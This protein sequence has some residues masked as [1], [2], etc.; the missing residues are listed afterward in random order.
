MNYIYHQL[1]SNPLVI[2]LLFCLTLFSIPLFAS[3]PTGK[4]QITGIVADA[5]S[6]KTIPY[7]TVTLQ[8]SKGIIKRLAS[9]TNG[10][11]EFTLDSI[12][13]YTVLVQSIGFQTLKNEVN[14]DEKSTKIELGILKLTPGTEKIDEV[15]VVAQKP[16]VRT[17]VD[18]IIYSIEADPESKTSNALDMLR[19]IP[20]V[21]VDGEDNIQVK[22]SSNFK[23]LLNGKS[24]SMLT[25]N[26][27]DVLRS[28]PASTIKDIEVIT[29]P[30]SKYEAEGTG[31][32][33]NIITAKKQLE[34]FLGRINAGIDTRGG[35]TGGIYAS[36]KIKKF[37]FSIDYSYGDWRNPKSEN[38]SSLEN[39][40]STTNRFT[41]SEGYNKYKGSYN[42]ATGEASYEIDSLNLISLSFWGYSGD[43]SAT[44]EQLT[45][46]F[47]SNYTLSRKFTNL[48]N[49]S[50]GYGYISGN[51]D[52]QR[53]YKKPDKTFT[54]SYKLETMPRQSDN[55]SN[56][57]GQLNYN[58]YRQRSTNDASVAEHTFQLD[59]YDPLTKKHQIE[60]GVKYIFRHNISNSEISRY[61]YNQNDWI[62]D[63]SRNNDLNYDQHV[64]GLYAGYVLKL[65]KISIKS[66]LRQEGT[67]NDGYFHSVKDTTFTNRM[68]NLIP[69]LT[70]SKELDK[71][72]N[73][74]LSY[75]QRLA[76]PGIWYLNPYINDTDPLN[77][78]YGNPD[79]DA[80]VSHTFNLSYGKFSDKYN[81][82]LSTNGAFANNSIQSI[83]TI[84]ST[85]VKR[86]TY[87]NIGK[88]QRYGGNLYGSYKPGKKL[89]INTNLSINYS[90]LESNDDRNLKNEGFNYNGSLN[91]KYNAWK[92]GSI[93]GYAGYYSPRIMLQGQYGKY[94]YSNITVS[95]ELFKKKLTAS[96][97]ASNPF[98]RRLKWEQT[99]DDPSFHQTMVSYYYY[100]M[101]RFKLS[102]SFGQMK[103]EIK[104]A[105]RGIKNED[106]KEEESSS[107]SGGKG[108]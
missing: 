22:G 106:K 39:F 12:G 64:I 95:Q 31:G 9:D 77:I 62:I 65:K 40:V 18:K 43:Y 98:N 68:F 67:I 81:L 96:V 27:R 15:V 47:D 70:L 89:T 30:S 88:T 59:Y 11:F 21:T 5:E 6:G 97:T 92:N 57:D 83:S 100:Q 85:G 75:T 86:T 37:G 26:P 102:Y 69:Y 79:L 16:L 61:D 32:I 3:L 44:G 58:S 91:M 78:S 29:N 55:E 87:K 74:K 93:S 33:I 103:G 24:S 52:Y 50:N 101:L 84:N 60:G 94:W 51:I 42:Y 104:K 46:D 10:K 17:E 35:F 73:I 108:G 48:T 23:I 34:G 54:V 105:K 14:I 53:T 49:S 56:I 45:Q 99:Y 80:E 38:Y 25:Q 36:S 2:L 13:T 20:L 71:G 8:S 72:Q 82:N 41:E 28:L 63:Q 76:R 1:K 7:A 19:K 4:Y 90:I 66:G 107:G